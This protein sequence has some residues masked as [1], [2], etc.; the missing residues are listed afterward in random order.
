VKR[1]LD[2]LRHADA[3]REVQRA[4]QEGWIKTKP[5]ATD[6]VARLLEATLDPGEA[7]AIALA[8]ELP[9]DLILL[10]E[11]DGR[12]AAERA[13]LRVT[14]LLGVLLRAKKEGQVASLSQEL[15]ALRTRAK[16]FLS[17]KLERLILESAGEQ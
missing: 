4:F 15:E 10:D 11:R 6:S 8:L 14:G 7:E 2:Q 3:L 16:F 17:A 12:A 9:A 13:G 5:L 1:E